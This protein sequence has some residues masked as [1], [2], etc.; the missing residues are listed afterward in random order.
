MSFQQSPFTI[1]IVDDDESVLKLLDRL[2]A[3]QNFVIQTETEG[4]KALK[5][6][7]GGGID[8]LIVDYQMPAMDGLTLLKKAFSIAPDLQTIMLSGV[9]GVP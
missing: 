8:L 5:Y 6:I 2:L 1:L 9:G 3:N 7:A 4:E